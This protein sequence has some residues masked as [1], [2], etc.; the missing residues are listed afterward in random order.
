M[1]SYILET[2]SVLAQSE[3]KLQLSLSP[4]D[5]PH[6]TQIKK[7][8]SRKPTLAASSLSIQWSYREMRPCLRCGKL[9]L[10][11]KRSYA[12]YCSESCKRADLKRRQKIR[13]LLREAALRKISG[14][15]DV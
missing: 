11:A 14:Q 1:K 12:K 4:E 13:R 6:S 15:S 2:D 10:K 3:S 7:R 9:L 8:R 5:Q